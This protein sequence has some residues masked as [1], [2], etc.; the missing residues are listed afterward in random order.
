MNKKLKSN[1][2][3]Y[4]NINKKYYLINLKSNV[5]KLDTATLQAVHTELSSLRSNVDK[6]DTDKL[7]TVSTD[8]EKSCDIVKNDVVKKHCLII[9]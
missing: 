7:K 2:F 5:D 8:F 6:I 3:W 1:R 9:P 4:T